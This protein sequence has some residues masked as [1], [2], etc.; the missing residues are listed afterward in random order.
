MDEL[1]KCEQHKRIGRWMSLALDGLLIPE[2]QKKLERH[3]AGCASCR[4]EWEAMQHVAALFEDSETVG[5][6]LGFAIHVERRLAERERKRRRTFGG[7]AVLTGSL[8]LAGVT[9]A[10]LALVIAGVL[11]WNSSGSTGS[12]VSNL[13][14]GIGLMGEGAVLFLKDLLLR[15][16]APLLLLVGIG[17]G[18]LAG[19]WTWLFVRRPGKS[20]NNGYA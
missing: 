15:Y 1:T 2:D 9:V 12:A 18:G 8:S 7:L 14:S 19:L 5:P 11:A 4:V 10:M 16:G 13:A 6:P 20:H 17:L 3:L